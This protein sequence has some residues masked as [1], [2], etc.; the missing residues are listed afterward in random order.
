MIWL[1]DAISAVNVMISVDV[2]TALL[3][4]I[5]RNAV[6]TIS[7]IIPPPVPKKPVPKP[8]VSPKNS[9][10]AISF[11]PRRWFAAIVSLRCVSGLTRKR[12]PMKNVRKSENVPSTTLPAYH[13][14]TLPATHML[15]MHAIMIHP[16]FR[17]IFLWRI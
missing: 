12:M 7:I 5:R 4:F 17:S 15:T 1:T 13:A 14:A 3:R 11:A 9:D 16:C 6:K 2:P 10:T 8:I